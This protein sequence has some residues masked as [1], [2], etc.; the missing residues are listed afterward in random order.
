MKETP[1]ETTQLKRAL[2]ALKTLRAKVESSERAR[3]EPIAIVGLGCRFPGG[4]DDP[5]RFW[6]MLRDG[7]D[8]VR[9]VPADRWDVDAH[10][11]PDPE[12]VGKMYSRAGGFLERV[13]E[14]DAH[15]FGIAPREAAR[16]DPQQHLLLEVAWEALENAGQSPAALSGSPT[17]VFLGMSSAD[18]ATMGIC[19]DVPM[20]P[21]SGTGGINS[22]AAGRI[23]YLLGLHGPT[24]SVDTACSSS[25]VAL[26]LACQSLRSG[27]CRMALVGGANAMLLPEMTIYFCKVRDVR[28]GRCKTFDASAD[29]YVRGEGCGIVVLKRLSDAV[30]DRDRIVALVRSTA[31]NHD[32]RSNG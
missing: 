27:E 5:V 31:I 3:T 23:S 14:F 17:G 24:L 22:V 8:G 15:F 13:D 2:I 20:D 32:G 29:G 25:L 18:Y 6:Q 12:A 9:D 21:Y 19:R 28:A 4:A 30:A 10:Y 11:D 26:H 16:M 7:I 1:D